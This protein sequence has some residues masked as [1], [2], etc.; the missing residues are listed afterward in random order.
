MSD[1]SAAD[2]EQLEV[3]EQTLWRAQTRFDSEHMEAVLAPGFIEFGRSG[4]VYSR[5]EILALGPAPIDARLRDLTV[6]ALA[7]GVALLT[8]LSEV[9]RDGASEPA[10]RSSIWTRSEGQWKLLF[11]Q[12]TPATTS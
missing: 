7:D 6:R 2:R 11:H 5:A 8:Y 1:L 10:N 3:L 9:S 4:R 12:G